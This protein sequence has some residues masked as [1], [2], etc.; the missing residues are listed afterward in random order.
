MN[1]ND[2]SISIDINA[3]PQRV[4]DV[5]SD[6]ERW[7]KWTPSVR[8]IRLLGGGPLAVGR[9]LF[10]R[11]PKLP[12]AMWKVTAIEPGRGFTSRTGS[13]LTWVVANHWVE[14][15]GAG[16]GATLSLRFGGLFGGVVARLTADLNNRYLNLE[17][18]GLKRRSESGE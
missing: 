6:V 9:R 7:H 2:F 13:F 14:P 15:F 4:W 18:A 12:P 16:S 17:A 10:I 3:P 11:Q 8:S 1:S 5:M